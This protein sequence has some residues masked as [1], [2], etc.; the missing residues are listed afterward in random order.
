MQISVNVKW[1]ATVKGKPEL[2]VWLQLAP[3]RHKVIA[4]LVGTPVTSQQQ[5]TIH[6]M[7]RR[8]DTYKTAD[9]IVTI[10]LGDDSKIIDIVYNN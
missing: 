4:Y 2:P 5:V 6:V 1:K 7:A 9:M 10:L 3:S 8:M